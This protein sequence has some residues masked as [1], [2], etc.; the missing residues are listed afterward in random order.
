MKRR[1][2]KY[3]TIM[4]NDSMHCLACGRYAD[5][6]HHVFHGTPGNKRLSEELGLMAPLCRECH[7]HVHHV[8]GELDRELKLDAQLALARVRRIPR[9]KT[10]EEMIR[11]F[12][13]NFT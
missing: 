11:I 9:D 6:W 12:G 2:E 13:R 3:R 1:R 7:M 10:A 5:E 4:T 8:G